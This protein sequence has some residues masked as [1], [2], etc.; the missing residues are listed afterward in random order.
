M[1]VCPSHGERGHFWMVVPAWFLAALFGC[2]FALF[3][4]SI[5]VRACVSPVSG[6]YNAHTHT[7]TSQILIVNTAGKQMTLIGQWWLWWVMFM[8]HRGMV[9]WWVR[10]GCFLYCPIPCFWWQVLLCFFLSLWHFGTIYLKKFKHND[11]AT[12][13]QDWILFRGNR[14]RNIRANVTWIWKK[15]INAAWEQDVIWVLDFMRKGSINSRTN[16]YDKKASVH[17]ST[18]GAHTVEWESV[19]SIS[20]SPHLV[21]ADRMQTHTH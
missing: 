18:V 12:A 13:L 7:H 6:W 14:F 5:N 16:K 11:D 3:Y 15:G 2:F 10:Y 4:C 20:S 21:V 19:F 9:W 8:N 17:F 1:C